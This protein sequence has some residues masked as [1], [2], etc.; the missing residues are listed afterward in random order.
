MARDL[1]EIRKNL[2]KR[3]RDGEKRVSNFSMPELVSDKVERTIFSFLTEFGLDFPL[4][5]LTTP[6]DV[7]VLARQGT[8]CLEP[9]GSNDGGSP[10]ID[11]GKRCQTFR[12]RDKGF[13]VIDTH[14]I[15]MEDPIADEFFKIRYT[16][17]EQENTPNFQLDKGLKEVGHW[18][19]NRVV[20]VDAEVL[21]ICIE[22]TNPFAGGCYSFE[23]KMWML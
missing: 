11:T 10:P 16:F 17:N 18:K 8:D 12:A 5:F 23:S 19:F 4:D 1:S 2:Y 6:P 9:M 20:L 3:Y 15:I 14:D 21:T 7:E 22:N 13:M